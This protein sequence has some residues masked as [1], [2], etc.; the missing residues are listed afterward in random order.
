MLIQKEFIEEIKAKTDKWVPIEYENSPF[1][2][3]TRQQFKK[4]FGTHV[5]RP[6]L[7]SLAK[8]AQI[9][10]EIINSLSESMQIP[11]ELKN[12]IA[13]MTN[14]FLQK[15]PAHPKVKSEEEEDTIIRGDTRLP[16]LY[17]IRKAYP[18]CI[19]PVHDQKLCGAQWAFASA[20]MLSDRF[21]I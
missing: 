2:N 10:D 16:A 21:C 7:K 11:T 5:A 3:K 18:E 4:S 13:D 6:D 20:G 1:K 14:G 8:K 17:D 9:S 12:K 15:Q 19:A